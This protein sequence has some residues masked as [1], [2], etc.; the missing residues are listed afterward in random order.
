MPMQNK[1]RNGMDLREMCVL[2]VP[3]SVFCSLVDGCRFYTTTRHHNRHGACLA[4]QAIGI[5]V[6]IELLRDI[7]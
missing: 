6:I 7:A 2:R 5:S 3:I 1:G 4:F